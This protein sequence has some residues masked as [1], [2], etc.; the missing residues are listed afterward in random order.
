MGTHRDPWALSLISELRRIGETLGLSISSIQ[1]QDEHPIH[2]GFID[3]AWYIGGSGQQDM[4]Y[5]AIFEI[6]TSKSDWERIRNN[7]AKAV[8]LRPLLYAQIFKPTVE[9]SNLEKREIQEIHHGRQVWVIDNDAGVAGLRSFLYQLL[10]IPKETRYGELQRNLLHYVPI[11]SVVDGLIE[12]S[13][14]EKV[15]A[16]ISRLFL[17]DK[18]RNRALGN[19]NGLK[20]LVDLLLKGFELARDYDNKIPYLSAIISALRMASKQHKS[21]SLLD[22]SPK[23]S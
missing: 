16:S 15:I 17:D 7:A 12:V 23:K 1:S 8:P 6:E 4:L 9:L 18:L 13:G 10:K 21:G 2:R 22:E 5:V 11:I 19:L 20:S 3:L 14:S